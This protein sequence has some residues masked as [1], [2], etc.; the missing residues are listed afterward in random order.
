MSFALLVALL[1]PI[2]AAAEPPTAD[3]QFRQKVERR[4]HLMRLV[5]LSDVLGLPDDKA[6]RLNKILEQFDERRHKLQDT[7]KQARQI[8][9]RA[10][11]GDEAAQK[12]LDQAVDQLLDMRKAMSDIDRDQYRAIAKELTPAQR[13]KFILFLGEFRHRLEGMARMAH[14]RP[15][16]FEERPEP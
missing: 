15:R 14:D 1:A 4:V 6:M 13:A 9:K 8:V 11:D 16:D 12:Q 5:E 3:D 2:A 7:T 10:A